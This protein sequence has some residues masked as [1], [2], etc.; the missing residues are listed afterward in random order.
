MRRQIGNAVPPQGVRSLAKS[1]LPLFNGDFEAVDLKAEMKKLSSMTI[2]ERL[3]HV[4][5]EMHLGDNSCW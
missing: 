5:A 4:S 3:A 2:K 1:L